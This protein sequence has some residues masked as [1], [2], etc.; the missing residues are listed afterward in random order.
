MS[1]ALIWK[2]KVLLWIKEEGSFGGT[3]LSY[4]WL[5]PCWTLQRQ[6]RGRSLIWWWASCAPSRQWW[7]SPGRPPGSSVSSPASHDWSSEKKDWWLWTVSVSL[8]L[9]LPLAHQGNE[10]LTLPMV[11][12]TPLSFDILPPAQ[13]VLLLILNVLYAILGFYTV[14]QDK[15]DLFVTC[16]VLHIWAMVLLL[17]R[18]ISDSIWLHI[19]SLRSAGVFVASRSCNNISEFLPTKISNSLYHNFLHHG[20]HINCGMFVFYTNTSQFVWKRTST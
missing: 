2:S 12:L 14:P 9:P 1:P 16:F 11:D 19:F 10:E 15:F 3:I 4:V 5:S 8:D 13:K 6:C 17:W 18:H 7:P 20:I